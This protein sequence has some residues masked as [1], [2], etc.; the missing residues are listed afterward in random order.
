MTSDAL[1][2]QIGAKRLEVLHDLLPKITRI[3]VLVNPADAATTEAQLTDIEAAARAMGLQMKVYNADAGA[4]IDSA[5]EA[6]GRDHPD[7]VFVGVAF[8][9]G[10]R[11]QLA[12]LATFY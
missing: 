7:A 3:S 5:F 12:H 10:R 2:A 1:T 11:V 8:L 9:N 6:M 4:G